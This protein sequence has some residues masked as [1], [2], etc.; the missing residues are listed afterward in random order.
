MITKGDIFG[1][2]PDE[3]YTASVAY[4]SMEFAIDQALK[5][6]SGGLGFPA[7]SQKPERWSLIKAKRRM[8]MRLFCLKW[9]F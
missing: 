6:Y 7:G 4:F 5:I 9:L 2:A 3:K 1:F 8:K